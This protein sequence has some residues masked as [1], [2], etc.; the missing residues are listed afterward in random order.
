MEIAD[1]KARVASLE[2]LVDKLVNPPPTVPREATFRVASPS[3]PDIGFPDEVP[4]LTVNQEIVNQYL[5]VNWLSYDKTWPH[6]GDEADD[7]VDALG[8]SDKENEWTV[9][10]PSE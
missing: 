2:T 8:D 5:N 4:G 10:N 9:A 7:E 6:G 3:L 1:L